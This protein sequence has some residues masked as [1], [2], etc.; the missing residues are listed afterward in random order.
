MAKHTQTNCFSVFDHF[1]GLALKGLTEAM[2]T[3]YCKDEG[4]FGPFSASS[5][6][7]NFSASLEEEIKIRKEFKAKTI[8]WPNGRVG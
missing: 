5:L 3:I 1:V 7:L 2:A 8:W 6:P 4:L